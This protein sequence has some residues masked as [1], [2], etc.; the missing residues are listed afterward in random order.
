MARERSERFEIAWWLR[1]A[2]T[3]ALMVWMGAAAWLV[4]QTAAGALPAPWA[5]LAT[6][7]LF[8]VMFA[9]A[10]EYY[11]RRA[12]VVDMEGLTVCG[13]FSMQT[14]GWDE[15]LG[16][17]PYPGGLPGYIIETRRGDVGFTC[18][19]LPGY[20]RLLEWLESFSGRRAGRGQLSALEPEASSP[21]V[22]QQRGQ[23]VRR[24][25]RRRRG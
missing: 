2:V 23:L 18:L 15:V 25:R 12:F 14:F 13:A 22:S 21:R 4:A 17:R 9:V 19:E 5:P 3:V 7:L 6:S 20:R 16:F 8:V 1:I 11:T 24:R 10:L